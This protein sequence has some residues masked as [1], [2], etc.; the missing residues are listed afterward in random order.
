MTN[1]EKKSL[2]FKG[3]LEGTVRHRFKIMAAIGVLTL[4]FV[5]QVPK[6]HIKTSIYDL[7]IEDLPE[8]ARYNE[9][10]EVF[11]S[12]EIIRVVV[13]AENVFDPATFRKIEEL[14]IT[15]REIE[16]VRRV[17]SLPG[18]KKDVDPGDSWTLD[19][20][21]AMVTPVAIFRKNLISENHKATVLTLVLEQQADR[22]K[23]IQSVREMIAGASKD[24]SLYQIGMPLVSKAL[25]D[26]TK[27]D[28]F[29]LPPITFLIIT[30]ILFFLF[31]NLACLLLPLA[32]VVM[33]LIWTFGLMALTRTPLSM[34]TMIVPVFLIAVGTAYCLHIGSEYL[35]A[36]QHTES[37]EEAAVTT[38]TLVSFPTALAVL[39][40]AIGLGSLLINRIVA[41]REFAIFSC[42]GMFSLL[43]IVLTFF[44]AALSVFP[45]PK[46]RGDETNSTPH[47]FDRFLDWII[48]LHLHKQKV[49]LPVLGAV[50]LFSILGILR[51]RVETSPIEYFKKDTEVSR[52]FHDIYRDLSGSFPVNVVVASEEADYFEDPE[53]LG[54]I[55]T[56]QKF[57]ETLPLVDKAVSF[58]EY[59][60]LVNYA[61]NQFDPQFYT[62]PQEGFEVRMMMNNYRIMLGDDMY[63]R[64]MNP[65]LNKANILLFTH[66]ASSRDFLKIR[67][68]IL[69]HVQA[70]FSKDL[71]WDVTGLGMV[72][73]ASSDLLTRGQVKSL[74]IT[75]ALVFGIMFLLFLSSKV[76]LIAIIPNIFPIVVVFGVMGWFGIEL[77]MVT[78]LIASIAIGLAVD[79]TIHYLVRYNREFKNCLDDKLALRQ[80]IKQ[81]GR[82][83][84]FTTLTIGVGFSI[85][86]LSSFKPTAI[87]GILMVITMFSALVGDLLILPSLMLHVELVTLWD[88]LRLK[89]GRDPHLGIPIFAGLTRTQ[90]HYV[91]MAGALREFQAEEVL[92]RKGDPSDF[93]YAVLSGEM[94]VVDPVML[95]GQPDEAGTP[96]FITRL[97]AG[98]L[99]G[100]MGFIRSVP[101]S[102]TVIATEPGELLQ[103]N[104]RMLKR[105]QWL[106][107]PTAH[108][109]YYNLLT[110]LSDR[111]ERSTDRLTEISRID[112]VTGLINKRG[113]MEILGREVHR[114]KRYESKLSLCLMRMDFDTTNPDLD[115]D[116]KDR[117][118]K[119]L[120]GILS[121]GVRRSDT[122]GRV[123]THMFG[124]IIPHA[125]ASE[126][127]QISERM[128]GSLQGEGQQ[129]GENSV[130]VALGLVEFPAEADEAETDFFGRAIKELLKTME[131][132]EYLTFPVPNSIEQRA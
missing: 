104:W 80:T 8:T 74:S 36:A 52:H 127:E 48:K 81:V 129:N 15:A 94:D 3:L 99:L 21:A 70:N 126:A 128:W 69:A 33:A 40:T 96:R 17:I 46:K 51:I 57:L 76:G 77:S 84:V 123:D 118:L 41:I 7:V 108:K 28:F 14:A 35:T 88:L 87:F 75:V 60:K 111:L 29:S 132:D 119:F 42:F 66:I 102:A 109:F 38:F 9:F 20:F 10:K 72:V 105:L 115:H 30:L 114:A 93:M 131:A 78:S 31:R 113:F 24:L 106:F 95:D 61:M 110:V 86:A 68:D 63:S 73:S 45:L 130:R 56:V 79:D 92:F 124:L 32:C 71:K 25:A 16:G 54:E 112:Y 27:K 23:V 53:H 34:M 2:S 120:A 47:L 13:K 39:T 26:F 12:D 117:M 19:R 65:E 67:D 50:A 91:L 90:A 100:E 18:I 59:M 107:P 5:T 103:L 85:L 58:A 98:D 101:R 62:L 6:L 83:I 121:E 37:P 97:K 64:F 125:S 4:L 44:P 122:L 49:T 22:D 1:P 11:G 89:I 55:E 43:V 116:D 82:P